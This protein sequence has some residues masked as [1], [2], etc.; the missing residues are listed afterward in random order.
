MGYLEDFQVQIN[1]R[2]FSKFW[3]LWEEYSM[4]DHVDPEEFIHLLK[5]I[6]SSELAKPF[7]QYVETALPLWSYTKDPQLSYEILKLL[8]DLETTNSPKLAELAFTALNE[9]YQA[10]PKFQERIR[11][12]GL[13]NRENF[14]GAIACYDLLSHMA[15]GKFVFHTGGWGAGEIVDISDVREQLTVEFEHVS[16]RKYFTFSNAFKVLVPLPDHSF[17]ARR[18]A[19][20][21]QLEKDARENPVE[22]I[23]LLLSDLGPK[24][25]AEIKDELCDLVIPEKDW[26]KWWQSARA[27]LKKNTMVDTPETLKDLFRLHKSEVT[28]EERLSRSMAKETGI[29]ELLQTTYSFV[30]DNPAMLKKAELKDSIQEK[31]VRALSDPA[32][33]KAQELQIQIFLSQQFGY[34]TDDKAFE[35]TLIQLENIKDLL[36]DIGILA[37]RKRLLT[38]I[39]DLRPDWI[40]LFLD[41]LFTNQQSIIRDYLLNELNQEETKA[42]LTDKLRYLVTHPLE[43]PEFLV[44]Y[45]QKITHKDSDGL[46][47]RDKEGQCLFLEALLILFCHLDYKTEYRDL[48]KKIYTILSGKRYAIVRQVL[49]GT[50]IEFINEFLL[51]VSK[52]QGFTDHDLKILRSLAEVVHPSLNTTK[53][54]AHMPHMDA[55]IIWSTEEGYNRTKTRM[56]QI[57]NVEIVENA[58]EIEAAR[59]LGD[60]RENS[61]YKFA[62][63]RRSRLNSELRHLADQINRA[64]IITKADILSDETGIGSIIKVRD[65]QNKISTFAIL[66]PWDVNPDQGILSLQ[67]QFA[68]AIVGHKQGDKFNFREEEYEI[69]SFK[70]YLD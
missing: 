70:S 41:L 27:K 31:L 9:R 18:F 6:K 68:Q 38:L 35:Q 20:P 53:S 61:E 45:F 47:F 50:P 11:M 36:E 2:N 32:V 7:G 60:L 8:I 39:R 30:R 40:S 22:V 62:L 66:G 15:K 55:H 69:L 59:G 46:P 64:R 13:R 21:D 24:T 63:E 29:E 12:I 16:G 57:N 58:R 28:H 42:P 1:N 26:V 54:K 33:T 19:N 23:K 14:Q 10:E 3:Q 43:A 52:C 37:F 25:A 17:L 51:L 49:E 67:S 56:E 44:W 65:S 34:H 48:S 5:A 4:D